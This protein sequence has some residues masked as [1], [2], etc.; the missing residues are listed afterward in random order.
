MISFLYTNG[1]PYKNHPKA[2][3]K[4]QKTI[5]EAYPKGVK[6]RTVTDGGA[7][8]KPRRSWQQHVQPKRLSAILMSA[9]DSE[10]RRRPAASQSGDRLQP[11][12][13]PHGRSPHYTS[14]VFIYATCKVS[15]LCKH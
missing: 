2:V 14:I 10:D 8:R 1:I 15:G 4:Q 9:M 11:L 5:S 7:T 6:L 12:S 13:F 3:I